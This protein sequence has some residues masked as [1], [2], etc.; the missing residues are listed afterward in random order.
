L[1]TSELVPEQVRAWRAAAQR[2]ESTFEARRVPYLLVAIPGPDAA[3]ACGYTLDT[4]DDIVLSSLLVPRDALMSELTRIGTLVEA[5]SHQIVTTPGC[6]LELNR[7]TRRVLIDDG[8]I[9][10][11]DVSRGA[12][13]SNLPAGSAYWT[14]LETET[15]GD[16]RL[17]DGTVVRFGPD[18][19]VTDGPYRGERVSHLGIGANPSISQDLGWAIVD[20]HRRGAV[21]LAL[22]EN[23][24]M[25]GENASQINVDLLPATPTLTI[26]RTSLLTDGEP[27]W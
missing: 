4:L 26:A 13:V 6:H 15:R 1:D 22:G 5:G 14:V 21:F 7:D 23:R 8:V 18:G 17:S 9:D 19:A 27:A 3:A 2:A 10:A 25:G 12:V 16:V 24:Y 11:V 20:E